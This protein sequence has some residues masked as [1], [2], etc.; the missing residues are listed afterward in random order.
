M[1]HLEDKLNQHEGVCCDTLTF[2]DIAIYNEIRQVLV[3]YATSLKYSATPR[4][5]EWFQNMN[6][7]CPPVQKYDNEF[8][9]V[10]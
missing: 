10:C 8:D 3:I 7:L 6:E 1:V 2:M 4:L 9:L 5:V